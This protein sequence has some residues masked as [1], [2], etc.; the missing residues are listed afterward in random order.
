[1]MI[2]KYNGHECFYDG[3]NWFFL[4]TGKK[5]SKKRRR[6]CWNGICDKPK[7]KIDFCIKF[8]VDFCNNAGLKTKYSCCGHNGNT[9]NRYIMF[10]DGNVI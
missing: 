10:K 4:D 7:G 5:I 3:K 1:M 6:R 9:Q 2:S 8:L